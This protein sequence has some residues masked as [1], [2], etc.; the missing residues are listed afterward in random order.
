[1]S[2]VARKRSAAT[3]VPINDRESVIA[4]LDVK[5][6]R[7]PLETITCLA[8]RRYVGRSELAAFLKTINE[9]RYIN[10]A[11][12]AIGRRLSNP[13]LEL[14]DWQ[15]MAI[16]Q[17]DCGR[18]VVIVAP[19]GGGKSMVFQGLALKDDRNDVFVLAPINALMT[20]Q[21]GN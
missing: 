18:D 6:V 10:D 13:Q 14:R 5:F 11:S 17:I 21:V 20:D 7:A 9:A 16:S 8:M 4:R 12:K 19:T 3:A 1:L 2:Q 15:G